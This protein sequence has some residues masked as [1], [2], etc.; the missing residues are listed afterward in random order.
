MREIRSRAGLV[1]V[2][3]ALKPLEAVHQLMTAVHDADSIEG[4]YEQVVDAVVTSLGVDRASLLLFDPDKVMRFKAWR[5]LSSGYRRVVEG[6]TPWS[7]EDTGARPVLVPDAGADPGLA[8]LVPVIQAEGIAALAF[9]PLLQSDRIVGKLMLYYD[10]P[11][12][13]T[14]SEVEVAE[15]L[16]AQVALALERRQVEDELRRRQEQL[17]VALAAGQMGTWEWDIRQ[18]T[19]RWSAT[20][21]GVHG[22]A[23]GEFSGT[24][25]AFRSDIHPDDRPRVLEAIR[26]A[27]NDE[28]PGYETE[29]RIV[30][31]DGSTRWVLA[32]G[33]VLRDD[34]GRPERMLGVCGD[35]TARHEAEAERAR[36]LEAERAAR[37][38]AEAAAARLASLSRVATSLLGA[39]SVD[40]VAEVLVGTALAEVGAHSGS[41]CLGYGDELEIVNAAGYPPGVIEHWRRFPL[42]ADL[43]A[44]EVVRSGRAVFICSREERDARYPIFASTPSLVDEA[45]AVI[46]L[47][48]GTVSGCLVF[49]FDRP[50]QFSGHDEIMYFLL[51]A[52]CAAA[53]ERARLY[54]DRELARHR[55]AFLSESSA[56]L[57]RS[58][59]YERTLAT[60]AER[61]V[62]HLADIC[63]VYLL[64]EGSSAPVPVGQGGGELPDL[65]EA[66]RVVRTGKTRFVQAPGQGAG[67]AVPMMTRGKTVGALIF[68]N[69]PGRDLDDDAV[70]L[71]EELAA[72]AATAIDNARLFRQRTTIAQTLQSSLLPPELPVIPGIDLAARYVAAGAGVE[73]GGDFYDVFPLDAR[74]F[75]VV[76]GD[77]CGQGVDAATVAAL[78]RHTVRSAAVSVADPAGILAHVNEVLLRTQP[79]D[80]DEPRFCTGVVAVVSP[81]DEGVAIEVAA[82]GHPLPL[83]RRTDGTVTSV[84]MPGSILGVFPDAAATTSRLVLRA[85]EV[86]VCVTDGVLER[87]HGD[88]IF[89]EA[90]VVSV[91]RSATGAGAH[92]LATAV[93]SAALAF[94]QEEPSDDVAVLVIRVA[95]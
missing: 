54:E 6:H 60:V 55:L 68:V 61:A 8:D 94:G 51:A 33:Q 13:F 91:L 89:G 36:L 40:E 77:V 84:G 38:D 63:A 28:G 90:G 81:G 23:P 39:V 32:R 62:P 47:P 75:V 76:L 7:P 52:R 67:V 10:E 56:A 74:R 14:A 79:A 3:A 4:F 44:S 26:A 41:L 70:T 29:Y 12:E 80:T 88:A 83:L 57:G 45:L 21:E 17:Q 65:P 15:I 93:E 95:G 35:T 66:A 11:H 27:L 50:R 24:V 64:D 82:G 31:P 72:R 37:L 30:R 19:V 48:E 5:G 87:R 1:P 20:L 73:V 71:A 25:E 58:L 34:R 92:A 42:D 49:G 69:R 43:P 2:E 59:D 18:R 53:L 22:L 9:V 78:T 85:G 86:L 46:P 16:A